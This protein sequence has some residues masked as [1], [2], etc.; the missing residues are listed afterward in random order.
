MLATTLLRTLLALVGNST[1]VV[2]ER[3]WGVHGELAAPPVTFSRE[4]AGGG[5]P[6]VAVPCAGEADWWLEGG[7]SLVPSR[8]P[9][10]T[11][12][13]TGGPGGTAWLINRHPL[14]GL[15]HPLV[16]VCAP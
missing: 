1:R 13:R 8:L 4:H 10:A 5:A 12:I 15:S 6:F 3:G 14:Y 7:A 16:A 2:V 9:N 11:D